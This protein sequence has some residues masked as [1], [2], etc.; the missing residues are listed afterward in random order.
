MK[1]V[2]EIYQEMLE[3]YGERTGLGLEEGCDLAVRLYAAASQIYSLWVQ[4]DWVNRQAFPQTATGEYL[5]RH[6][7]LRGLERKQAQKAEGKVCFFL[8]VPAEEERLVPKGTICMTTGFIR[9]E[10]ME[11]GVISAGN[12][13]VEVPVRAINPGAMGNVA[14]E[15]ISTMTVAP[16]G[17][18]GCSNPNPCS[19]GGD[20]EGDEELRIRVLGT[21]RRMPNGANAAFYE[22]EALSFEEVAAAAVVARPRG[23]GTV[24]IVVTELKGLPDQELL[25]KLENHFNQ[26]REIAVDVQVR[27]P[28]TKAVNV[29]IAVQAREGTAAEKQRHRRKRH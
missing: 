2:D 9:F 28:E 3:C 6:A 18:S 8:E 25:I 11:A 7:Q 24:D 1:T 4:A 5:D 27:A 23:V 26:C 15:T 10:T 22:Q 20:Q 14:A 13:S 17:I 16:V 19:G 12:L 29:K 21:Y